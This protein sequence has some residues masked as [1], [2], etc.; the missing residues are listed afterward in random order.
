[1]PVGRKRSE[2]KSNILIYFAPSCG[3]YCGRDKGMPNGWSFNWESM[4]TRGDALC[5][6]LG[7][8]L[9]FPARKGLMTKWPSQQTGPIT[10]SE[11]SS[12]KSFSR[13]CQS[14]G[15]TNVMLLSHLQLIV[16]Y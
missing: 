12:V 10:V 14:E 2:A 9:S 8:C 11:A 16:T 4:A 13:M 6:E 1:M 7:C 5:R 3:K 15:R